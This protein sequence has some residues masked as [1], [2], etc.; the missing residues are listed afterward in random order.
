M[1]CK[2]KHLVSIIMPMFNASS[3][4]KQAIY[5]VQ[6]QSYK[7]WELIIVDDCSTDDSIAV[8]EKELSDHRIFLIKNK[9]NLGIA[10]SRNIAISAAQGRYI[11]F[12]DSDDIWLPTKLERQLAFMKKTK[13]PICFSSYYTINKNNIKTGLR[14][15]PDRSSYES[16]LTAHHIGTLTAIYDTEFYG[17][18]YFLEIHHEDYEMWLRLFKKLPSPIFGIKEPLA[19]YRVHNGSKSSNKFKTIMWRWR[20]YREFEKLNISKSFYYLIKSYIHILLR[21]LNGKIRRIDY[22]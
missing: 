18:Q 22:K 12:L 15:I 19:E 21:F 14:L 16:L 6:S 17:K 8:L 4:A 2:L 20:I 5:S 11:A 13:F 7:N 1:S 9:K 3:F 10:N